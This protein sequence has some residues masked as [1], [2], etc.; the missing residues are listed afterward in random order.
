MT[1]FIDSFAKKYKLNPAGLD[2]VISLMPAVVFAFLAYGLHP[3]LVIATSIASAF[4]TEI[5]FSLIFFNKKGSFKDMTCIISSML[6]AFLLPPFTPL[7]TIAFGSSMAMIF[8]K[9]AFG[10]MGKNRFNPAVIGREFVTLFLGT[11]LA[12][13]LV[14]EHSPKFLHIFDKMNLKFVDT[15]IWDPIGNIGNYSP[16][17]LILG[18]SYLLYKKRITFHTPLFL[19][20]VLFLGINILGIFGIYLP[21]SFG[22]ATLILAFYIATDPITTSNNK[23]GK[24]F[25]GILLGIFILIFLFFGLNSVIFRFKY[26]TFS[27]LTLNLFVPL[28]NKITREKK[29]N[30]L[31]IAALAVIMIVFVILI[32]NVILLGFFNYIMYLYILYAVYKFFQIKFPEN[33]KIKNV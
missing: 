32:S 20:L 25:Q 15:L 23:K 27:I 12:G 14:Q 10:G 4:I 30:I 28:I 1:N 29:I 16:L 33:K 26:F 19:F 5:L 6:L 7:Y 11:T 13:K 9:L 17:F 3:V 2:V 22:G 31:H 21:Y 24:V 18:G 8:G